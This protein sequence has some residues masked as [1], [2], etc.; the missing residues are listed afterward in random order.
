MSKLQTPEALG[1][2]ATRQ[3]QN[4]VAIRWFNAAPRVNLWSTTLADA[5][6]AYFAG[7]LDRSIELP[8]EASTLTGETTDGAWTILENFNFW[9]GH[10]V[11]ND[12]IAFV[13]EEN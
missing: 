4:V 6:A 9:L 2:E 10:D 1:L 11:I 8:E 13:R 5:F 7:D 3:L 12:I